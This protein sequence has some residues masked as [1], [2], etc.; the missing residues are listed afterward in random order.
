MWRQQRKPPV[1]LVEE[2]RAVVVV[3][4]VCHLDTGR[5][6]ITSVGSPRGGCLLQDPKH[7]VNLGHN[8]DDVSKYVHQQMYC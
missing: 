3:G 5:D 2:G 8:T 6:L 7:P 4:V 1:A